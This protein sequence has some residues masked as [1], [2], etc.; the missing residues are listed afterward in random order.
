MSVLDTLV[1]AGGI[2][3]PEE[4]LYAFTQGE[5]KALLPLAGKPMLQWVLD[6]LTDAPGVGRIVIVGL[7]EQATPATSHKIVAHVPN[8][9]SLFQNGVA[10]LAKL[11]ELGNITPQVIMCSGDIP[12]ITAEMVEWGI[13]QCSDPSVDLYHFDVPSE[14]MEARFPDSRRTFIHF[15]NE[16]LAGGDF[17][18]IAPDMV[19]RHAELWDSL[20]NNRKNALKQALRLGPMFFVKLALRRLRVEELERRAALGFGIQVRV[21][22]SKYA[23]LGMDVDKPVQLELCRRELEM[24]RA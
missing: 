19:N 2:P 12:L 16:D 22:R 18:I 11:R 15:A 10:G 14:I 21:V 6:T 17:H 7:E 8:A 24:R 13:A 20:I 5:A 4:P 9:G 3:T 1:L 23:E